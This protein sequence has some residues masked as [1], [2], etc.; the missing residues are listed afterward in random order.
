[1][2]KITLLTVAALAAFC[3]V[4]AADVFKVLEVKGPATLNPGQRVTDCKIVVEVVEIDG[5]NRMRPDGTFRFPAPKIG[6]PLRG[7]EMKP[8]KIEKYKVGDKLTL[9]ADWTVPANV[10]VGSEGYFLF[11]IYRPEKRAFAKLTGI[12]PVVRFKVADPNAPAP[13]D[14]TAAPAAAAPAT[15]PAPA[16]QK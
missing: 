2:K 15:N 13:A 9:G 4:Q 6:R 12:S 8:W 3:T 16:V 7:D 10:P 11:R 5:A 1:M 14:K